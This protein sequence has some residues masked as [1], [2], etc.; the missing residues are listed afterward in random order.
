MRRRASGTAPPTSAR[1]GDAGAA[2]KKSRNSRVSTYGFAAPGVAPETSS[3]K[4]EACDIVWK[5]PGLM[6]DSSMGSGH[7]AGERQ[8]SP[9]GPAGDAQIAV[10]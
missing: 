2:S 8:T 1:G 5:L 3:E 4:S 9:R 6:D 10:T 7:P